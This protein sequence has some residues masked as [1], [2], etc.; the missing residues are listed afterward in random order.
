MGEITRVQVSAWEGKGIGGSGS[1]RTGR[2]SVGCALCNTQSCRFIW[3][4]SGLDGLLQRLQSNTCCFEQ[5]GCAD[6]ATQHH[7]VRMKKQ[8]RKLVSQMCKGGG[9][10][11][12]AQP[13]QQQ[14]G[15]QFSF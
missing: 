13:S 8:N 7:K 5:K 11:H 4:P 14:Q 1:L 15:N 2:F 9:E 6:G 3:L 12:K 10:G